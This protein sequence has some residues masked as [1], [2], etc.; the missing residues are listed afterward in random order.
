[1]DIHHEMT[2]RACDGKLH[3]APL[4]NPRRILDIG[5]GT[6]IWC[7][8]MGD[9]YPDAEVIG[10]DFSPVQ[11]NL[12]PRNVRFEVDD[13]EA[14]WTHPTKFDYI[15]C[16]FMAGSIADWPKLVQTCYN[17]LNPGGIAEFQDGDFLAYSEDG[18]SKDSWLEKWNIDFEK[19][20]RTGGRIVRPGRHLEDWV[21]A[22]GFEDVHHE[23]I[24]LPIGL[25]PKDRQMASNISGVHPELSEEPQLIYSRKQKDVGAF[26]LVQLK[27]GLEG[28]SLALF[29]RILGWAPEEVQV[30]LSKVRKDLDNRNIHAQN[31][32]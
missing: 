27:E 13:V 1:M 9:T 15:H 22:A 26:N 23:K 10:N 12:V 28:F 30:L 5:T 16:R 24:R 3:L 4:T 11:P 21:R 25:W 19:A 14:P 29:T 7:I 17:N 20:A 2:L 6:G 8:E 18:S 31:D 32:M